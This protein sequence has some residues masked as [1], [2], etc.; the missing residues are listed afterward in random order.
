[1]VLLKQLEEAML[2]AFETNRLEL[3]N[4]IQDFFEEADLDY[5]PEEESESEDEIELILQGEPED[6]IVKKDKE[7]FY[8][9]G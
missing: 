2:W 5:K 1:M 4:L 3:F 6:L 8:S 7:G 9:L